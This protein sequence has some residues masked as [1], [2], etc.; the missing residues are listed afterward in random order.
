MSVQP[1]AQSAIGIVVSK[2]ADRETYVGTCRL[3][4]I[5]MDKTL[6]VQGASLGFVTMPPGGET[7]K[8]SKRQTEIIFVIRGSLSLNTP[9]GSVVLEAGDTGAILPRTLHSHQNCGN[10]WVQFLNIITP[11]G[12][13]QGCRERLT[14]EG[15]KVTD[16]NT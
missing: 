8:H 11:D 15:I 1:A 14:L 2:Q 13:E 7:E 12:P 3:T 6:G 9:Q 16:S 10:D 5:L 4:K